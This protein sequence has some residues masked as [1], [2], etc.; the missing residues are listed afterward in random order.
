MIFLTEIKLRAKCFLIITKN[1]HSITRPTTTVMVF[2]ARLGVYFGHEYCSFVITLQSAKW[3]E[4]KKHVCTLV[5][6]V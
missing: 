6:G 3:R 5:S 1:V 4:N 2:L